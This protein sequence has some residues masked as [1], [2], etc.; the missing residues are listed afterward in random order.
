[1]AAD[2]MLRFDWELVLGIP[3]SAVVGRRDEGGR[4]EAVAFVV[5]AGAVVLTVNDDTDEIVVSLEAVSDTADWDEFAALSH[6]VGRPF[7][8]CWC[9]T[10]WRGYHDAFIAA[11]G[12]AV[13]GDALEPRV[14]FVGEASSLSC[15][16]LTPVR[17]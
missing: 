2:D 1:M 8:W 14:M 6:V 9:G 5:G 13:P 17:I 3:I 11:F 4:W 16:E 10:N 12:S 7:G 15:L